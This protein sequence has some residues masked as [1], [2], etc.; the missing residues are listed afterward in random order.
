MVALL[1]YVKKKALYHCIAGITVHLPHG[2]WYGGRQ[3]GWHGGRH[4][5]RQKLNIFFG[6]WL[7]FCSTWWPIICFPSF[8]A[9]KKFLADMDLDIGADKEVDKL[10]DMVV[11]HWCWLIGPK[12]F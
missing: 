12:F 2:G 5:G 7:T 11:G 8:L 4:G 10:A 9:E 3:G 1:N 6:S